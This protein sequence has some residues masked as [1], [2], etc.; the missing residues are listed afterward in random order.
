MK[1]ERLSMR[2]K[3][4]RADL[5]LGSRLRFAEEPASI[6]IASKATGRHSTQIINA[7]SR[8]AADDC[9]GDSAPCC[10]LAD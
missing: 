2:F 9:A 10:A 6:H 3:R 7:T 5:T 1:R 4:R 8:R